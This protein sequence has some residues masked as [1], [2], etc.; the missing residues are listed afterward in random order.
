[1]SSTFGSELNKS[2]GPV[3]LSNSDVECEYISSLWKREIITWSYV[4]DA[5]IIENNAIKLK[6]DS[7]KS[8]PYEFISLKGKKSSFV[9]DKLW[10]ATILQKVQRH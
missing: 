9:H 3:T 6:Y 2:L 8:L 7:A 10:W 1:M 4:H 5:W